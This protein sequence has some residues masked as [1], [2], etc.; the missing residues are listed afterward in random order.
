M[1]TD[2]GELADAVRL[3]GDHGAREKRTH[4]HFGCNSRIDVRAVALRAELR[5]P[6]ADAR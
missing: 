3:I 6:P 1:L 5:R 4:E 2:H